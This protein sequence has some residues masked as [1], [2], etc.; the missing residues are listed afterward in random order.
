MLII[1]S[2]LNSN[3][4]IRSEL[5]FPINFFELF[6]TLLFFTYFFSAHF[7]FFKNFYQSAFGFYYFFFVFVFS[8][9]IFLRSRWLCADISWENT[10]ISRYF[11][12]LY[13][14]TTY[15]SIHC[16]KVHCTAENFTVV[17]YVAV[18]VHC[19]AEHST[20]D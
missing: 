11:Q 19:T 17:Y 13:T 16:I 10:R 7:Y 9:M 3:Y 4:L 1:I 15:C 5:F 18:I 20:V 14:S 2:H 6:F 12:V 8:F